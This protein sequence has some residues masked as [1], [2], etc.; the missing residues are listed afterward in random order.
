MGL[1][2]PQKAFIRHGDVVGRSLPLTNQDGAGSRQ[3]FGRKLARVVAVAEHMGK[4]PVEFLGDRLGEPTK[5]REHVYPKVTPGGCE[6]A[7]G[8][9]GWKMCTRTGLCAGMCGAG[10]RPSNCAVNRVGVCE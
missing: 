7:L 9:D 10:T 1:A 4:Q 6:G 3:W 2:V 8:H 5:T